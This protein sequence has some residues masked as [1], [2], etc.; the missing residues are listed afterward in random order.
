MIAD[1]SYLSAYSERDGYALGLSG[2]IE[3]A[4]WAMLRDA[5]AIFE[6]YDGRPHWGKHHF[7]TQAR[8]ERVY[9]RY[10]AFKTLRRRLDPAGRLFER[11]FAGAV[12][13]KRQADQGKTRSCR[14]AMPFSP[15][16]EYNLL[17]DGKTVPALSG[18]LISKRVIPPPVPCWHAW[19][20]AKAADIDLAVAAARRAFEGRLEPLHAV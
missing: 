17:I 10:D 13:L 1:D 16:T 5:D 8:L 7:M 12:C 9:P 18:K 11:P 14:L 15:D 3:H 4:T 20:K 2:P 6:R 19:R